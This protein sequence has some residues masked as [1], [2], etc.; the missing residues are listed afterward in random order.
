MNSCSNSFH[1]VNKTVFLAQKCCPACIPYMIVDWHMAYF[2]TRI[3][4]SLL[5]HLEK[6]SLSSNR[7]NF[8]IKPNIVT[9]IS[10]YMIWILPCNS[11]QLGDKIWCIYGDSDFFLRDCFYL[12]TLY[13]YIIHIIVLKCQNMRDYLLHLVVANKM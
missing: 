11:C 2:Y 9:K 6:F 4:L 8:S 1:I 12:H 7:C 5:V 10:A 13:M 3:S